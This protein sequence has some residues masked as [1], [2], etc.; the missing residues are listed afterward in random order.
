MPPAFRANA[1][2]NPVWPAAVLGLTMLLVPALGVPGELLLQDTLKSALVAFG[3]LAAALLFFWQQRRRSAPLLWHG[4]VALP[5]LL[6]LYAL[7]S[8]AWSHTYLAA[9]E[10]VRWFVLSLLLW[11]GLN[12]LDRRDHW[13][14]LA[15]GIHAGALMASVWAALQFWLDFSLF[16]QAA[17][18]ASTFVNRNFFAEY[19]VCALPFSVCLLA[20][21]RESRWLGLLALSLAFNVV[22]LLMT[23]TRSALMALL[24]LV[25]V[26]ALILIRYRQQLAFVH[27]SRLSQFLIPMVLAM[28]VL[29]LGSVPPKQAP[30]DV[31]SSALRHSVT[32][33]ASLAEGAEFTEGSF[34]TR[35]LMW[36]ATARMLQ[37]NPLAGVGAGAWEVQ[38]PL[39]QRVGES[40]ETD[41]YAHMEVLQLLSEYGLLVGGLALAVLLAYLLLSAGKTWRLQGSQREEA[42]LRATALASLI[43]L[44]VVS[45][46]GFPMRLASTGALFALCLGLLAASDARLGFQESFFAT[47]LRWR[48]GWSRL[49]LACLLCF[50]VLAAYITQQAAQAERNIVSAVK[51]AVRAAQSKPSDP[52]LSASQETQMLRAIRDGIAINPHYRKLTSTV[53]DILAIRGDWANAVW[54]LESVAASR[55]NI[56]NVWAN[57]ALA[58]IQLG[59]GGRAEE[60]LQHLRR[61][62]PEAP[63]TRGLE[64]LLLARAAHPTPATQM[65]AD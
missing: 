43:A 35:L 21:R 2:G 23:G 36:K 17:A 16:P 25:P 59:Q 26:V 14:L 54:I 1:A 24:V 49:M 6:L 20:S 53:A 27:W 28:G 30:A 31:G 48:P 44:L 47:P 60:A 52:R 8:M 29:A 40:M 5:L 62:Q 63:R 55:P 61:L 34:S 22:A 7:A 64:A 10:A 45:S 42:P 41:Y 58:Y 13:V 65:Q 46:A 39:Y 51:L 38:I 12:C 37:A 19:A 15:W 57:I 50:T 3:A 18:P 32:R 11:L 4:L 33:A 56:A 9:V